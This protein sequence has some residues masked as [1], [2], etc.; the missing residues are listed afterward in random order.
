MSENN[1]RFAVTHLDGVIGAV[2]ARLLTIR[3]VVGPFG[4]LVAVCTIT[5]CSE[6]IFAGT[7]GRVRT[8]VIIDTVADINIVSAIV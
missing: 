6:P 4:A 5:G 3:A 7:I 8:A 1:G 2:R